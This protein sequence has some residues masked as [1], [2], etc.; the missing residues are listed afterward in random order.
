MADETAASVGSPAA[1]NAT[2]SKKAAV[3]KKAKNPKAKPT[4]P[5]TSEMVCNAIK[6]LKERGGSSLRAIKKYVAAN[7]KVD[8]E[9]MSPFIKKYVKSAVISGTLVQTKG[10]G[11]SGSFKLAAG[12]KQP[13]GG[14]ARTK[15]ATKKSTVSKVKS[16]KKTTTTAAAAKPKKSAAAAPAEKKTTAAAKSKAAAAAKGA[17]KTAATKA[18]APKSSPSKAKKASK[19]GPTKKPKA[20]KPKRAKAVAPKA[21]A[22]KKASPKKK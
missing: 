14:E 9:K 21:A 6:S 11:A 20:P 5:P 2:P 18:K 10:K 7:Y 8:A 15:A 22:A 17:A 16:P 4:H 3:S 12:G 13:A 19:A 1:A